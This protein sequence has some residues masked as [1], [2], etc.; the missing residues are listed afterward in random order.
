ML[1]LQCAN[2]VASLPKRRSGK[3]LR[4]T[5][6]KSPV[7]KD[8]RM[9]ATIDDP[10]VLDEIGEAL[11]KIGYAGE[12]TSQPQLVRD[13]TSQRAVRNNRASSPL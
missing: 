4:G 7:S 9:P 8:D 1:V 6:A 2:M 13:S 3:I 11:K 5:M 12:P 10:V